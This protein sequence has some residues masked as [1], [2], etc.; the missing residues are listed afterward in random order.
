MD[1]AH[2][3]HVARLALG[4]FDDT[5][6]AG[7]H[8]GDARERELLWAGALLH[9]IGMTIDYDDHHKHSRYLVLSAGLPGFEQ[10][11]VALIGQA[12]RFH[13]KGN[14]SLGP[15]SP[16]AAGVDEDRVVRMSTLLRLAED[17]ERS[18]DQV[19]R[20][21]HA[22]VEGGIVRLDLVADGDVSVPRWAAGREVE[23]FARA[24]D[25]ALVV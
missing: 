5:A 20:R 11:E 9:D 3:E 22:S 10:R 13:R 18:R 8:P 6:R 23:L 12:V 2:T 17:L 4:L 7:L 15:F 19:V 21:A 1:Q 16:L 25:R 24:F 14:P